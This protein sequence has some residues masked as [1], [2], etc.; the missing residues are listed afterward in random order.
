M[1]CRCVSRSGSLDL[2]QMDGE[3]VEKPRHTLGRAQRIAHQRAAAGPQL[4]QPQ[5]R[6]LPHALPD[7]RAPQPDQLAEHLA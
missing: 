1:T 2:D 3:R 7:D 6:G 5:R 4:D